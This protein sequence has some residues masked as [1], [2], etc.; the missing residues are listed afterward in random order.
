MADFEVGETAKKEIARIM[1]PY[2]TKRYCPMLSYG[3]TGFK[4][5]SGQVVQT[6]NTWR[7]FANE[8]ERLNTAPSYYEAS[9]VRLYVASPHLIKSGSMLE[10][11]DGQFIFTNR[12]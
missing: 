6:P 2:R 5:S 11:I 4:S 10:F 1:E 9:G 12:T 7:V 3:N 8:F